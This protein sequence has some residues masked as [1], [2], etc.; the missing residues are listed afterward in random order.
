MQ[1][2]VFTAKAFAATGGI[3]VLSALVQQY[4]PLPPSIQVLVLDAILAASRHVELC[5]DIMEPPS[6][7]YDDNGQLVTG[8]S[9]YQN[10]LL[11]VG[12]TKEKSVVAEAGKKLLNWCSLVDSLFVFRS[13]VQSVVS[14][15]DVRE[16][17]EAVTWRMTTF[18]MGS[19]HSDSSDAAIESTNEGMDE[20]DHE[21]TEKEDSA[22][23]RLIAACLKISSIASALDYRMTAVEM[24]IEACDLGFIDLSTDISARGDRDDELEEVGQW[25]AVSARASFVTILS[26]AKIV[27]CLMAVA[28]VTSVAA[29]LCAVVDRSSA[30]GASALSAAR[31]CRRTLSRLFSRILLVDDSDLIFAQESA[32]VASLWKLACHDEH[33]FVCQPLSELVPYF[34]NGQK[35]NVRVAATQKSTSDSSLTAATAILL[36]LLR[37]EASFTNASMGWTLWIHVYVSSLV[38]T[39]LNVNEKTLSSLGA[40]SSGLP[41]SSLSD[42]ALAAMAALSSLAEAASAS[43]AAAEIVVRATVRD[44]LSIVLAIALAKCELFKVGDLMSVKESLSTSTMSIADN[45]SKETGEFLDLF[46]A[47]SRVCGASNFK[48]L[49]LLSGATE[50]AIFILCSCVKSRD[51]TVLQA[52]RGKWR[53]VQQ[54][55]ELILVDCDATSRGTTALNYPE[56]V[57]VDITEALDRLKLLSGTELVF[58]TCKKLLATFVEGAWKSEYRKVAGADEAVDIQEERD[59]TLAPPVGDTVSLSKCIDA[60]VQIAAFIAQ[61]STQDNPRSA[62]EPKVETEDRIELLSLL[63]RFFRITNSWGRSLIFKMKSGHS[64]TVR[65]DWQKVVPDLFSRTSLGTERAWLDGRVEEMAPEN[66]STYAWKKEG[67]EGTLLKFMADRDVVVTIGA[68]ESTLPLTPNDDDDGDHSI[69][70]HL[71]ILFRAF[72]AT[73]RVIHALLPSMIATASINEVH[74][75]AHLIVSITE[76]VAIVD[77]ILS[78]AFVSAVASAA[79]QVI[80]GAVDVLATLCPSSAAD[81][82]VLSFLQPVKESPSIEGNVINFIVKQALKRPMLFTAA[83]DLITQL[84]PMCQINLQCLHVDL[85]KPGN[86]EDLEVG[87]VKGRNERFWAADAQGCKIWESFLWPSR[88]ESH[89]ATRNSHKECDPLL[90]A[91]VSGSSSVSTLVIASLRT[92][93]SNIHRKGLLLARRV[94]ALGGKSCA[95]V[96]KDIAETIRR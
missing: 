83:V 69:P 70:T 5:A 81:N 65:P 94:C 77:A 95:I 93:S 72:E 66:S 52:M 53:T 64:S 82:D 37:R 50:E 16:V 35:T 20:D 27:S 71:L 57:R 74:P 58:T 4:P 68:D 92:A 90:G 79:R 40:S 15:A 87:D 78:P 84:L 7:A 60:L 25:S 19:T 45:E 85:S 75:F 2:N 44:C 6:P 55:F 21:D 31:T 63:L 56:G 47:I 67:S 36:P 48:D 12:N 59:S 33:V 13:V 9:V 43:D 73:L 96:A 88:P 8:Y 11:L 61:P 17:A 14:S 80:S 32:A 76:S 46:V 24:A 23:G 51:T 86:F 54:A 89:D 34:V 42:Q 26:N 30:E 38:N 49:W 3:E 39:V 1:E 22:G 28:A 18:K 91:L 10:V 29:D 41:S 62:P